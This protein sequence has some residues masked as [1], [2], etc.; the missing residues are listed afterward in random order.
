MPTLAR[1]LM[2]RDTLTIPADTPF[3]DIRHLFVLADIY[4]APVV[5]ADGAVVG[6]VTALDLLRAAD[7]SADEDRDEGEDEEAPSADA[8]TAGDI[9]TPEVIWVA[10]DTP[11]DRVAQVMHEEGIHRVLVGV[12]GELE[13]IL[14]S[15]D[16]LERVCA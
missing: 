11:V 2:E 6:I 13:G 1:D 3:P 5:D 15:F 10:P 14:T 7:Q 12:D 8:L 4:G 9:A 16:L